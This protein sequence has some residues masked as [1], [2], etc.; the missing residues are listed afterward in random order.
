MSRLIEYKV[1][2]GHLKKFALSIYSPNVLVLTCA[3]N[4]LRFWEYLPGPYF[5]KFPTRNFV[6]IWISESRSLSLLSWLYRSTPFLRFLFNW[7]SEQLYPPSSL[8]LIAS[9]NWSSNEWSCKKSQHL[10]VFVVLTDFNHTR[11]KWF[12]CLY[13]L[14]SLH[15]CILLLT[16]NYFPVQV[17]EKQYAAR[18]FRPYAY[19]LACTLSQIPLTLIE[20]ITIYTITPPSYQHL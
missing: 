19:V 1:V 8:L 9:S 6:L 5:I 20:V 10:H 4:S 7:T 13:P 15:S 3:S 14:A 17:F 2:I 16:I 18:F 11:P 12:K